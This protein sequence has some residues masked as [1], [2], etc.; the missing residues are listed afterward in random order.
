MIRGLLTSPGSLA[1]LTFMADKWQL[2]GM[3]HVNAIVDGSERSIEHFQRV[4]LDLTRR[5]PDSGD[6]TNAFL[7][8]MGGC[9]FEF[10]APTER[11]EK[12]NGQ[13]RLLE[14][15][16]DHYLGIE[17]QVPDVAAAREAANANNIRIINDM[18]GVFFTYPGSSFGIA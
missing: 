4:G 10:F 3:N 8:T 2:I 7:M 9:M 6:G 15:F 1:K 17:F 16:G 12:A 14:K 11:G 18:G 5:I 13:G